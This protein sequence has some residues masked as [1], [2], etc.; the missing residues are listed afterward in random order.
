MSCIG[1]NIDHLI[2]E[3]LLIENA[4]ANDYRMTIMLLKDYCS[5]LTIVIQ[6]LMTRWILQ[7]TDTHIPLTV[8]PWEEI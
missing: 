6:N 1:Y 3:L 8:K 7:L 2:K 5:L 4:L